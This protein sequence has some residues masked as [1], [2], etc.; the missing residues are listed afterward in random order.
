MVA[1]KGLQWLREMG[2]TS[3]PLSLW[4]VQRVKGACEVRRHEKTRK[5]PTVKSGQP[6]DQGRAVTYS[7]LPALSQTSLMKACRSHGRHGQVG[8]A[9]L[10]S[11]AQEALVRATANNL[12]HVRKSSRRGR[13]RH[14]PIVVAG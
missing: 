14:L 9:R 13:R 10:R 12:S 1:G 5:L 8:V 7:H 4:H 6:T 11:K 2:S 3:R